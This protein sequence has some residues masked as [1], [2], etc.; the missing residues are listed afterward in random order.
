M[1][2]GKKMNV[3]KINVIRVW[4]D[5]KFYID[6]TPVKDSFDFWLYN[7]EYGKALYMFGTVC[8]SEKEAIELATANAEQYI[9]LYHIET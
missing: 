5:K 6:I 1:K 9:T 3:E 7:I 2:E 4:I 8:S